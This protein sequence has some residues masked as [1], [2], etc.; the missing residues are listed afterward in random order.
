MEGGGEYRRGRVCEKG[1][2]R[3]RKCQGVW[4]REGEEKEGTCQSK[5][6]AEW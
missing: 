3:G 5:I 6:V 1:S 2:M 4:G